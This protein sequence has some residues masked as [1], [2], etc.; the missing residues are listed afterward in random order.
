MNYTLYLPEKH[1]FIE[2]KLTTVCGAFEHVIKKNIWFR[3]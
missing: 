2:L 3:F 1:I